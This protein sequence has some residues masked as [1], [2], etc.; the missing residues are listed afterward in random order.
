[1]SEINYSELHGRA[2]KFV[3]AEVL[4][5]LKVLYIVIDT[6]ENLSI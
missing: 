6:N 2:I 1:M 3:L 4:L 5:E